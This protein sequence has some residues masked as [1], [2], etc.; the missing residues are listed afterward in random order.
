MLD[1]HIPFRRARL[2]AAVTVALVAALAAGCGAAGSGGGSGSS[3]ARPDRA[4]R[5]PG[6]GLTATQAAPTPG[7]SRASGPNDAQLIAYTANLDVRVRDVAASSSRADG[8]VTAAGGYVERQQAQGEHPSS[9]SATTTYRVPAAKYRSV[10][11]RLTRLGTRL[12]LSQQADNVTEDVA[13]VGAR[14][15]SAQSS[16]DRLRT[17]MRQA[18]DVQDVLSIETQVSQRESELEALQARQ[19]ALDKQVRYASVT[20]ALT[21]PHAAPPKHDA[22][23]LAGLRAGWHGL[24]VFLTGLLTVVGAVLP[25]LLVAGPLGAVGY[26]VLRRRRRRRAAAATSG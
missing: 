2:R 26:L 13:D 15:K 18:T 14:V 8:I 19:R 21:G 9:A 12:S 17:L 11:A 16:L 23:L 24:L 25:F 1:D 6:K 4:E 3:A 22:G 20:L 7:A 10:L 5:L